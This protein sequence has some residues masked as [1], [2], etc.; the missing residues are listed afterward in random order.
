MYAKEREREREGVREREG[1]SERE[2][3][4]ERGRGGREDTI[5]PK[6]APLR[7]ATPQFIIQSFLF[8]NDNTCSH[9]TRHRAYEYYK[10][11]VLVLLLQSHKILLI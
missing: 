4:R 3:E 2:G 11:T 10:G 9:L 8:H 7:E 6:M 1:G 5:K